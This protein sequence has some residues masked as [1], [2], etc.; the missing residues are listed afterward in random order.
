[1]PSILGTD[2]YVNEIK[3]KVSF[4]SGATATIIA[5]DVAERDYFKIL[6]SE[7]KVKTADNT[8]SEVIGVTELMT[9]KIQGHICKLRFLIMDHEDHKV[10]LGLD[11]FIATG[12]GLFIRSQSLTLKRAKSARKS[13]RT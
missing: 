1:M 9:V 6:P 10:L 3:L 12:A 4:D 13:S 7:V 2:G 5:Y 11:L 8:V